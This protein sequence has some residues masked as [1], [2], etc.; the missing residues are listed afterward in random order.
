MDKLKEI[1]ERHLKQDNAYLEKK[2]RASVKDF[3][4]FAETVGNLMAE[5]RNDRGDL[6][7]RIKEQNDE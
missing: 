6:L 5:M 3:N 2:I 1:R 4:L 7:E